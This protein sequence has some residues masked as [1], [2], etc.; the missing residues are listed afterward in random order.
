MSK[1]TKKQ[2]ERRGDGRWAMGDGRWE[3]GEGR[4]GERGRRHTIVTSGPLQNMPRLGVAHP[5]VVL[6]ICIY[7][8]RLVR[9]QQ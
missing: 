1:H 5:Q 8:L 4:G 2:D 7:I 3:M 6:Y 9:E